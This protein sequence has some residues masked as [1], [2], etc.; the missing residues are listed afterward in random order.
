[1]HPMKRRI[2]RKLQKEFGYEVDPLYPGGLYSCW[3]GKPFSEAKHLR[4]KDATGNPTHYLI[5]DF[6]DEQKGGMIIFP[7]ARRKQFFTVLATIFPMV[8][9]KRLHSLWMAFFISR[10]RSELK[11]RRLKGR[12]KH[13]LSDFS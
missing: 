3:R 10:E 2:V 1:M 6:E 7:V 11:I 8:S 13:S 4:G 5:S 9:S 12:L